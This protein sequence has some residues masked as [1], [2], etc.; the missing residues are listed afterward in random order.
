MVCL[1]LFLL[2]AFWPLY[3]LRDTFYR[4]R[5]ERL[6]KA[7][8]HGDLRVNERGIELLPEGEEVAWAAI[9]KASWTSQTSIWENTE[10]EHT[11][12]TLRLKDGTRR[13]IGPID[14]MGPDEKTAQSL[15][16]TGLFS[17]EPRDRGRRYDLMDFG[18]D[19]IWFIGSCVVGLA[20]VIYFD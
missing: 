2:L 20:L 7:V 11:V 19:A 14:I 1:K 4:L 5:F 15:R 3:R 8:T 12:V 16:G 9:D 6:V 13:L 17:K 18:L 10:Y